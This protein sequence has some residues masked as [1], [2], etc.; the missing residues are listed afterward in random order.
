ML[1]DS[2]DARDILVD[3]EY[4]GEPELINGSSSFPASL[5]D[6]MSANKAF[7]E[8]QDSLSSLHEVSVEL[9]ELAAG[10]ST[11]Q[12][13]PRPLTCV[14]LDWSFEETEHSRCDQSS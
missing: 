10:L 3:Y 2:R 8:L 7:S 13:G 9:V 14:M 1:S 4:A 5:N 11:P 12:V 6:F